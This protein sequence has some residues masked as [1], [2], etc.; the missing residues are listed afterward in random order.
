MSKCTLRRILKTRIQLE[1][2]E[3]PP[4]LSPLVRYDVKGP[5]VSCLFWPWP[6]GEALFM[7]K[8]SKHIQK[9]VGF[10]TAA[11]LEI[12]VYCIHLRAEIQ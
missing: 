10:L 8:T 11:L 3:S 6:H 7:S 4:I 12:D 1:L 5:F 2:A 9:S